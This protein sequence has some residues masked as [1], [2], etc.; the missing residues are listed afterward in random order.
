MLALRQALSKLVLSFWW[1]Y[2]IRL[3]GVEELIVVAT[4]NPHYASGGASAKAKPCAGHVIIN[5]Q[6]A[7]LFAWS[8]ISIG[9][10]AIHFLRMAGTT[11]GSTIL[12]AWT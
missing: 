7:R 6:V 4:P 8:G 3:L 9:S 1:M 5:I 12:E 11:V 10:T 2:L